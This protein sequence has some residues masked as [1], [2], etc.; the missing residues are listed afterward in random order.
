MSE[1]QRCPR[2][3]YVIGVVNVEVSYVPASTLPDMPSAPAAEN[4][5]PGTSAISQRTDIVARMTALGINGRADRLAYVEGVI[6]APV[7]GLSG[8]SGYDAGLVLLALERASHGK[9]G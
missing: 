5:A 9:A 1:D 2:C 6:G 7:D 8:L 4:R 3:N